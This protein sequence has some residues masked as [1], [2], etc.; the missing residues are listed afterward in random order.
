L[1]E[2]NIRPHKGNR[3]NPDYDY[4]LFRKEN[5]RARGREEKSTDLSRQHSEMQAVF[6]QSFTKLWMPRS[7]SCCLHST[8]GT[9]GVSQGKLP[10]SQVPENAQH[11][12]LA[13][14]PSLLSPA[15][16]EYKCLKR[17]FLPSAS[18]NLEG[19]SVHTSRWILHPASFWGKDPQARGRT[20][21][22]CRNADTCNGVHIPWR[23]RIPRCCGRRQSSLILMT[24]SCE[25]RKHVVV[26]AGT[27]YGRFD[28][29]SLSVYVA[30]G[31]SCPRCGSR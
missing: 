17:E 28:W 22:K 26:G 10:P 15:A 18:S 2:A 5:P 4:E 12:Q 3:S 29:I 16:G 25:L 20:H 14:G 23:K 21:R 9:D 7:S 30:V 11:H 1:A 8:R 13:K 19:R 27:R 24:R 31:M 6:L